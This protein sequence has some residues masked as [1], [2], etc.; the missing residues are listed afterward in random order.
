MQFVGPT[1]VGKTTTLAKIAALEMTK[2]HQNVAFI[3]TD[4]YRIAAVEQL[5]TYAKILDV[6]LEVAYSAEDYQQAMQKFAD[7]DLIFVDTAGRNFLDATYLN[8][9][10][11][12]IELTD[13]MQNYLVLSLTAKQSDLLLLLKQ[14]E[15]VHIDGLIFT[16]LDETRH[17]GSLFTLPCKSGLG[18]AYLSNGQAVPD[19]L[20][21]P[22]PEDISSFIMG[23]FDE[24]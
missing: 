4:T 9:L 14:F 23:D 16:K 2:H 12:S 22:N 13:N 19:D 21:E 3:T 8:E 18:V 24:K 7:Y 17:F 20:I 5:K 11:Q 15:K 1:G 10:E 6:P